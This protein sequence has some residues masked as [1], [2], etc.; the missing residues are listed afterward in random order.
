ML[1]HQTQEAAEA[2]AA[3]QQQKAEEAAAREQQRLEWIRTEARRRAVR[4]LNAYRR[5]H[6]A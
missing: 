4:E 3:A 6:G 1:A 2:A 5:R